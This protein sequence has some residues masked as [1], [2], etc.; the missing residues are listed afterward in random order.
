MRVSHPDR[1]PRFR[2][3]RRPRG[4]V[5]NLGLTP[6][7]CAFFACANAPTA[8]GITKVLPKLRPS[9]AP[10]VDRPNSRIAC[11]VRNSRLRAFASFESAQLSFFAQSPSGFFSSFAVTF[12]TIGHNRAVQANTT[13]IFHPQNLRMK[14]ISSKF[15][16][17]SSK[18]DRKR[19]AGL[20][21]NGAPCER[22]PSRALPSPRRAA[23]SRFA[24]TRAASGVLRRGSMPAGGGVAGM[25]FRNRSRPST[26]GLP[27]ARRPLPPARHLLR[28]ARSAFPAFRPLWRPA[29]THLHGSLQLP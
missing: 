5:T 7:F 20:D 12:F 29:P 17:T 1:S 23:S 11:A 13:R 27:P 26:G 14:A 21:R 24:E 19:C 3:P 28:P 6:I 16:P 2:R 8:D 9:H 10:I 4:R 22:F 25:G 18:R 15:H